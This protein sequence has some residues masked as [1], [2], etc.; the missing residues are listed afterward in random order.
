MLLPITWTS[1]DRDKSHRRENTKRYMHQTIHSLFSIANKLW[2]V[3]KT[4]AHCYAD[5][6]I[7]RLGG[8]VRGLTTTHT[9]RKRRKKKKEKREEKVTK[10]GRLPLGFSY[11]F[12]SFLPFAFTAPYFFLSL[13]STLSPLLISTLGFT[14]VTWKVFFKGSTVPL[15]AAIVRTIFIIDIKNPNKEKKE[16]IETLFCQR[17]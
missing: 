17:R 12:S 2:S 5:D 7:S 8:S 16:H 6:S 11:S 3:R 10:L 1:F 14:P 13:Y 15:A 9:E 4:R